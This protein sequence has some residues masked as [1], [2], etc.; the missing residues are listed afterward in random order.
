MNV[1]IADLLRTA[2]LGTLRLGMPVAELI[3]LLG[4]PWR[5]TEDLFPGIW[6]FGD[7][8]FMVEDGV[9]VS[10]ELTVGGSEASLPPPLVIDDLHVWTGR[11]MADVEEWLALA[12][13]STTKRF[14][15]GESARWALPSGAALT[16]RDGSFDSASVLDPR[17]GA[18]AKQP[19]PSDRASDPPLFTQVY[20]Y[21]SDDAVRAVL[22]DLL[23]QRG[24]PRGE[25]IALQLARHGKSK[26][27][28]ARETELER[29]WRRTW[30]G[31]LGE[32]IEEE[33]LVFE[34]GFLARARR[35]TIGLPPEIV[36]A[37]QW[38]TLTHLANVGIYDLTLLTRMPS[39][40]HVS[41]LAPSV[42]HGLAGTVL[43]W[44]SVGFAGDDWPHLRDALREADGDGAH[45]PELERL[46]FERSKHGKPK[47]EASHLPLLLGHWPSLREIDASGLIVADREALLVAA[48]S[49]GVAISVHGKPL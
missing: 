36:A 4:E 23:Q 3:A 44:R 14:N 25:L 38:R 6:Q 33:K 29:T 13:L 42:L 21:P 2:K 40:R 41:S 11:P 39:L 45:L 48:A 35:S 20:A 47:L 22:G 28:T 43:P 24:D 27:P 12:G 32:Y 31:P 30:I 15:S 1:S 17:I 10:I 9:V 18:T 16:L 19:P 8:E 26:R 5:A 37:D 49:S 7:L 34:R 46:V